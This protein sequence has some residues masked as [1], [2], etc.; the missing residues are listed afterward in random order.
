MS[1]RALRSVG[2]LAAAL[3][4][5]FVSCTDSSNITLLQV[6]ATGSVFG[7]VYVDNNTNGT[8]DGGDGLF[9]GSTILL[10]ATRGQT[11]ISSTTTDATGA[12]RLDD[13]PV[14]S[15][16]VGLEAASVGDSLSSATDGIQVVVQRDS[17]SRADF[18]L[19]YPTLTFAEIRASASGKKVFTSG[20]ALNPRPNFGDGVVHLQAASSYLRTINVARATITTGDSVRMLGRVGIDNG[21]VVLDEVTPLVLVNIA[22]IP[23]PLVRTTGV[24]AAAGGGDLDAALMRVQAA[25]ISDTSTVDG[26]FHFWIDDGSGRL[27]VV[28]RAFLQVNTS[29]V[30][31][32][33]T[34]RVRDATGLLVPY[35]EPTGGVRWRLLPRAGGDL[36][37]EVKQADLSVTL[38]ADT[39]TVHKGDT[40]TFTVVASNGGPLG[41]TGV[42][43]VDSVP[44]GLAFVSATATR[45]SYVAATGTWSLGSLAVGAVD[46]LRMKA[47]VT[48]SL[49]TRTARARIGPPLNEVDP[50][51]TNNVASLVLTIQPAAASPGSAPGR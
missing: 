7:I 35:A 25:E 43:V 32:D 27:E 15:Y 10:T 40:V 24:A 48:D 41:A 16:R 50:V 47:M 4:I 1:A 37:L 42:Q 8:Y 49:G 45:G 20:I 6:D 29:V 46:T 3:L 9:A 39:T 11:P 33:T 19:T 44:T 28:F 30:R 12:F 14:G 22:T 34:V 23:V 31:P 5:A 36:V 38:S 17:A 21:Q 18:G 13:V 2:S 26:D 51:A